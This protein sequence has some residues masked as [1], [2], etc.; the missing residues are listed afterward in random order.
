MTASFMKNASLGQILLA[1]YQTRLE[2]KEREIKGG[3]KAGGEEGKIPFLSWIVFF[4]L[5]GNVANVSQVENIFSASK[6]ERDALEMEKSQV[7]KF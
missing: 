4:F 7:E 2:G 3:R 1:F 5:E 6:S